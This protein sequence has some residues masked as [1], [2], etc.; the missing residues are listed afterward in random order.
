MKI[1]FGHILVRNFGN[2][3]RQM[4][5]SIGNKVQTEQIENPY[6]KE[7][8]MVQCALDF[9]LSPPGITDFKT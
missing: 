7:T 9:C 1:H 4:G 2:N 5:P 8:T 6:W 3:K